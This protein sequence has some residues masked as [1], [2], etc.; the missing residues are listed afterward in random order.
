MDHSN[1]L[2][3]TSSTEIRKVADAP[4]GTQ[5]AQSV[6][7]ASSAVGE[8]AHSESYQSCNVFDMKNNSTLYDTI[9]WFG[10]RLLCVYFMISTFRVYH[11]TYFYLLRHTPDSLSSS[12]TL[13]SRVFLS[14]IKSL[15]LYFPFVLALRRNSVEVSLTFSDS[16]MQILNSRD[17]RKALEPGYL[18]HWERVWLFLM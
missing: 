15:T 10:F 8:D 14:P 3:L 2:I 9:R 18:P 6:L 7:P 4:M 11:L 5:A 13:T 16:P 1:A 12:R 17:F